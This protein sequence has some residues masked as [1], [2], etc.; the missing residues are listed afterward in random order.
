MQECDVI[1]AALL[2]FR[3]VRIELKVRQVEL[4]NYEIQS[5]RENFKVT[6]S[7]TLL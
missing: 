6:V 3:H 5:T 7:V 2:S 4:L 1:Y